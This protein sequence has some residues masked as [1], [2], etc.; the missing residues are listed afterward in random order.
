VQIP[1]N[2]RNRPRLRRDESHSLNLIV[3]D[4]V[5]SYTTERIWQTPFPCLTASY[6][7]S[8]CCSIAALRTS[9]IV[10]KYVPRH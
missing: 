5:C 8:Q 6:S 2:L 9:A 10:A 1:S 7:R 4:R 3:G